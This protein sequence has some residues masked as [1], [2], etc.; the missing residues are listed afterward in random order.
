MV[1]ADA[2]NNENIDH[3][4]ALHV[5]S[6]VISTHQYLRVFILKTIQHFPIY[7]T[8]IKTIQ[9]FPIYWTQRT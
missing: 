8:Q 2:I 3:C 4:Y 1:L 6:T 7:W 5:L 9:H